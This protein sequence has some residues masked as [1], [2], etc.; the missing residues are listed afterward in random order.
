MLLGSYLRILARERLSKNGSKHA[1][2]LSHLLQAKSTAQKTRGHKV[3][4]S[5]EANWHSDQQ[6]QYRK[7]PTYLQPPPVNRAPCS[8]RPSTSSLTCTAA[9]QTH[10]HAQ[11]RH[12]LPQLDAASGPCSSRPGTSA[13]NCRR[14]DV[15]AML[16]G[17]LCRNLCLHDRREAFILGP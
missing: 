3:S 1:S 5:Q 12:Q 8:D 15:K 17:H 9:W 2:C 16:S 14:F 10:G 7:C 6:V 4:S 11:V 13:S